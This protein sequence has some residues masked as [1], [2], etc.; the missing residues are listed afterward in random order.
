MLI[1]RAAYALVASVAAVFCSSAV[2]AA[3]QQTASA[4]AVCA[5]AVPEVLNP[6]ISPDVLAAD[7][8]MLLYTPLVLYSGTEGFKP[9]LATAWSWSADQRQLTFT[10]RRDVLWHDGQPLTAED[11]AWTL[12]AAADPRYA[13]VAATELVSD[14]E[15]VSVQQPATV[16]VRF[17]KPFTAQLEPFV[18]LPILPRH[19]LADIPPGDFA[20]APYNRAPVGSGPYRYVDRTPDRA[21]R[22][23][24][25]QQYPGALGV[26]TIQRIVVRPIPEPAAMLIELQTGNVDLCIAGSALLEKA[27]SASQLTLLGVPPLAVQ[28]LPLNLN[29]APLDDA[30]VRRA[31]SAALRRSEI[32]ALVSPAARPA[33]SPMPLGSPWLD[34]TVAQPDNNPALA[35]NLLD[36]AG[37]HTG[38][39]GMRFN[40]AGAPLR[41]E[42]AGAQSSTNT[43]TM[44]QE[45]L[46][47]VGVAVDLRIMEGAAYIGMLQNVDARPDAMAISIIPGRIIA[48]DFYA[49][50]HSTSLRNLSAYTDPAV[51]ALVEQLRS[52]LSTGARRTAYRTVQERVA[53]DV[54]SIYTVYVPRL[55]VF[56]PRLTGVSTDLNGPFASVASWRVTR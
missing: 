7:L 28:S 4:V 32:A 9:Y 31:M 30:R 26:A 50:L 40:S 25:V 3:Q 19:I 18:E 47:Q 15:S 43:L 17:R 39:G 10:L 29:R 14:V 12:R 55:A 46:R 54:P 41:I 51:D 22:F 8:R 35:R 13:F 49:Q 6:A 34:T 33:R 2:A 27:R 45:Q 38:A 1:S 42:L 24:R 56:G 11:V 37:W 36:E 44:I 52:T 53:R 48:P 5:P 21:I 16:T 23:D 20:R